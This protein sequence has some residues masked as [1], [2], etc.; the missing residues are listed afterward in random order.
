MRVG[1]YTCECIWLSVSTQG[2]SITKK[3]TYDVISLSDGRFL[4]GFA[5]HIQSIDDDIKRFVL[6]KEHKKCV[7]LFWCCVD[8]NISISHQRNV[9]ELIS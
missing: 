4:I 9:Q 8:E 5:V 7:N 1:T 2:K 6:I 3:N